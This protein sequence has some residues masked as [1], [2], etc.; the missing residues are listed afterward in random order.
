MIS[1]F[2]VLFLNHS[3]NCLP[4]ICF[5]LRRRHFCG[6]TV[7]SFLLSPL[8]YKPHLALMM[9]CVRDRSVWSSGQNA[10]QRVGKRNSMGEVL[11]S[12]AETN[13]SSQPL[14]LDPF[15]GQTIH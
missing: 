7:G 10:S 13:S 1:A 12:M 11:I 5:I 15:G 9:F 6:S 4:R 3:L 14:G 2:N 8:K